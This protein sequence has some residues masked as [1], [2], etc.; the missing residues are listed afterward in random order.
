MPDDPTLPDWAPTPERVAS[1]LW[2]HTRDSQD[3][4]GEGGVLLDRPAMGQFTENTT[5]TLALVNELIEQACDDMG[6]LLEGHEPCRASLVR[7]IKS[8]TT[9]LAA[10]LAEQARELQA[11]PGESSAYRTLYAL[12]LER[13]PK[14]A[15]RVVASCPYVP[16]PEDPSDPEG[17]LGM[18]SPVA[19][20]PC[21]PDR[22]TWQTEF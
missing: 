18:L 16:D 15:A 11:A 7:G 3:T 9:Y 8:A 17:P 22:V 1:L 10:A 19:R 20:L 12:W 5:P 21:H 6:G 4:T 13:G 14:I 2:E